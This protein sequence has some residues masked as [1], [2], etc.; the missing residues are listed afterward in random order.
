MRFFDASALVKRYV[1][2]RAST[3]VRR[4]LRRGDVAVCRLSE[5]EVVA[6]F[7]RLAR[8]RAM[9]VAQ[10]D[11]AVAAFAADLAAWTVVEIQPDVTKTA[12][13]LLLRHPLRAGDAIQLGAALVLQEALAQ[14][15]D[16]F[17]AY[18]EQLIEAAR[19]EQL[20]VASSR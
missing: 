3:R 15:I 13:R 14:P 5:V 4:L 17:V 2:E 8:D 12:R 20:T 9:S 10:R 11:R 16:E 7:A 6:A 19:R 18:D 1:R